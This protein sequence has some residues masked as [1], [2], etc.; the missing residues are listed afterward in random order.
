MT[1]ASTGISS[2]SGPGDP[3]CP[4]CGGKGFVLRDVEITHPDFGKARPCTCAQ[5]FIRQSRQRQLNALGEFS[6]LAQ[7]TFETFRPEGVGL[8][9]ERQRIL[10]QSYEASRHYAANPQGWLMLTGGFGVGKTHLAAA[11]GN[12]YTSAGGQA[13][14]VLAPDLLDH[15]RSTY[16]PDSPETFDELF[17]RLK[18]TPLLILDDLGAESST[19]WAQ[20]KLFQLLSH[21]YLQRLPTVITTNLPLESIEPRLRSRLLDIDLVTRLHILAADYRGGGFQD[22]LVELSELD[23]HSG[24]T[25][26]AFYVPSA[27][28]EK[29]RRNLERIRNI[30]WD[31]A[32]RPEGWLALL[33]RPGVG[34]THLA[35]AIANH[36][37]HTQPQVLFVSVPT[38]LDHL[39]AAF[40]PSATV[41]YDVRLEQI[42][43]APVLVLDDLSPGGSTV[44]AREKLLQLLDHRY[45][46]RQPTVFTIST[47]GPDLKELELAEPRIASR[48]S[49]STL[50]L[51]CYLEGSG[52]PRSGRRMNFGE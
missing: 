21:R 37:R 27:G 41:S 44:W 48:I 11:V 17:E 28:S 20:E 15:L 3:N 34:K 12:A 25:F 29:L 43:R 9:P 47:S 46:S 38:L 1:Q 23:M 51:H 14:F 18:N 52:R 31:Y 8:P 6:A 40:A 2:A 32:Q 16:A 35:A 49:D 50:C 22:R 5:D 45:L 10:R 7:M 42:K 24:Q 30:T 4:I 19:Q 33:G 13:L 39:R 36:V 26:D